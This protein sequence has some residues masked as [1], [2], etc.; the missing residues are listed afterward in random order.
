[1]CDETHV[2]FLVLVVMQ[3]KAAYVFSYTHTK[4]QRA[5]LGGKTRYFLVSR[6]DSYVRAMLDLHL[7]LLNV[8]MT[9]HANFKRS[10]WNCS[11]WAKLVQRNRFKGL[12]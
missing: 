7:H 8:C 3:N 9:L 1:M 10:C 4:S 12:L 2:L 11:S 6:K 5:K